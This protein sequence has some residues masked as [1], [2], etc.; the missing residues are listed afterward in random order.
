MTK[1][2]LAAAASALL[3]PATAH[4]QTYVDEGKPDIRV[5]IG[6]GG[7]VK[8][9]FIGSDEADLAPLIRVAVAR[10]DAD[11]RFSAPDDGFGVNLVRFGDLALG[12][13]GNLQSARKD[14]DAGIAIGKVDRTV[15]LGGFADYQL[16]DSF[17][18][19]AELRKGL[20]GHDGL[21]GQ[22]GADAI[23]RQGDHY[24]LSVGPRLLLSDGRYQRAYFG[25]SP[26][27]AVRTGLP[28]YR[29]SSGVYGV[30][31]V[32][33]L[34]GQIG[35]GPWGIVGYA[36]YDRL[37]GDAGKSPFIRGYGSRDQIAGGLALSYTFRVKR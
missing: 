35:N 30:G 7:Q 4:A 37:V 17:R 14:K 34:A 15:E 36:R 25:V 11:F 33:G 2:I 28:V 1:L 20:G 21:V 23:V 31:L 18:L 12:V 13:A 22:V 19:R 32:S 16:S 29:P 8:P 26:E 27:A 10:G 9:K 5:R 6:L 3:L 24:T